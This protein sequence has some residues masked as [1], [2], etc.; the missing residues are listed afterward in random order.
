MRAVCIV[1]HI[2]MA[3]YIPEAMIL[4][5]SNG[6]LGYVERLGALPLLWSVM[7]DPRG[8]SGDQGTGVAE[9]RIIA[10]DPE[11]LCHHTRLFNLDPPVFWLLRD[12]GFPVLPSIM[13]IFFG[14]KII[15]NVDDL[16]M[17]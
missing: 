12:S 15:I 3:K 2:A 14:A 17:I 6:M 4:N 7:F 5:V 11:E 1:W 10:E 9:L 8:R 13:A 16:L